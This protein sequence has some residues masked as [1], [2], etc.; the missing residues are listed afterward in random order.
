[1]PGS[2]GRI[3]RCGRLSHFY[4]GCSFSGPSTGSSWRSMAA[5][6][7]SFCQR[8]VSVTSGRFERLR[9]QVTSEFM[10]SL[11]TPFAPWPV[12]TR[13]IGLDMTVVRNDTRFDMRCGKSKLAH[14]NPDTRDR[15]QATV[16]TSLP[17]STQ[18]AAQLGRFIESI[19][20]QAGQNHT[21]A[22]Q[23]LSCTCGRSLP[24]QQRLPTQGLYRKTSALRNRCNRHRPRL[25]KQR[26][27]GTLIGF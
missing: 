20:L 15:R 21:P 17:F 4:G 19:C 2:L 10:M 7:L 12:T 11:P 3:G 6:I 25:R 16:Q 18:R 26:R 23:R 13:R 24:L 22:G 14:I 5:G 8:F 1:M 27:S 9:M